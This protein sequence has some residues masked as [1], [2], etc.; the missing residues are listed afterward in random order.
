[1]ENTILHTCSFFGHREIAETEELNAKIFNEIEDL[2]LNK[3]VDTFLFGSRSMFD[4]MCY[5]AVTKLRGKYPHIKRVYVRAEF[6]SIGS[7]YEKY[8]LKRYEYTYY[9]QKI[10]NAGKAAYIERNREMIDNSGFC[11]FYYDE[12]YIP[13]KRNSKRYV[14]KQKTKSGTG[15]AYEYAKS[16]NHIIKNL[17]VDFNHS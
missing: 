8:L 13:Q 1:M 10:I 12:N 4:V 3:G 6:P 14:T 16:K 9:P 5:Q 7:D 11:I 2:I 17:A 15:I